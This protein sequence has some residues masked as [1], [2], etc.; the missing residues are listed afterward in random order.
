MKTS[1]MVNS[2]VVPLNDF[3][4]DYIA[5]ILCAI[6]NSFGISTNS[7]TVCVDAEEF[8]VYTEKGEID[9]SKKDFARQLIEST[10]KG[11][12]SPLKG[13]FWLQ[14][15]TITTSTKE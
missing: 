14:K 15:I 4:Q 6:A 3:M 9:I 13:I 10:V 2:Y 1:L 8:H 7:V 5:N 12:L 11:M